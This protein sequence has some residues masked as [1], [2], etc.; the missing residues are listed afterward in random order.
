[1]TTICAIDYST[2]TVFET[3]KKGVMSLI[4]AL[5]LHPIYHRDFGTTLSF[6]LYSNNDHAEFATNDTYIVIWKKESSYVPPFPLP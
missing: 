3:N 4:H 1:M 5:D 2:S 6:L